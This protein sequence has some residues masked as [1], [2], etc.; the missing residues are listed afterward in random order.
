MAYSRA[1][2]CIQTACRLPLADRQARSRMSA[3]ATSCHHGNVDKKGEQVSIPQLRPGGRSARVQESVHQ[4]VRSCLAEGQ[5][6]ALTVPM[7]AA[8][9]GVTPSTIYRRWGDLATLLADVAVEKMRPDTGPLDTGDLASDLE[10]WA[11]QYYEEM[12]SVPGRAMMRDVL[13]SSDARRPMQCSTLAREQMQVLVER[14]QQRAVREEAQVSTADLV[15]RLMDHLV[16]P[17]V[18]RLLYETQP[19][20]ETWISRLV[21]VSLLPTRARHL[22]VNP[23][24]V[25]S[26]KA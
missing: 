10:A 13:A 23:E 15:D 11:Q 4:A 22:V 17:L 1:S 7:I 12:S 3:V 8:R 9:A 5:R 21:E 20:S 19:M 16:A 6:D 24:R 2:G 26:R 18:Y 25:P 14:A